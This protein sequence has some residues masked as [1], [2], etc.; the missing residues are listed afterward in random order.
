MMTTTHARPAHVALS[1]AKLLLPIAF[2]ALGAAPARAQTPLPPW[3][4]GVSE[5]RKQ[6]ADA[7]FEEAKEL[8][9]RMM[10]ADARAKYDEALALWEQPQLRLYLG[11]LLR[12]I[13][14]PLLAYDSLRRSLQWGPGSLDPDDEQEARATLRALVERDLAAVVIRC[15]EP[16]AAVLLDGV[17]WF[18][19]PGTER[20]MVTPGEHVLVARKRGYFTVVEHIAVFAGKEAS[21]QLALSADTVITKQRWPAWIP[22]VTVGA[23]AAL[24]AAGGGL[25]RHADAVHGDAEADF[26]SECRSSCPASYDD[27][28][29]VLENRL[30]IG[31]LIVGGAT[32]VTGTA[33]LFMN[34][35]ETYRPEDRGGV[36]LEVRPAASPDAAGLSARLVF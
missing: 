35:P 17:P 25:M 3:H 13:G 33:L 7:L 12:T 8:H 11:R 19:G 28:G 15:D 31:A 34:R 32:A 9:Q 23:G 21:G 30:A 14:R 16:G 24:V 36:K 26:R 29:S 18:V 2:L 27:A 22:W 4:Q 5:E 6:R 1:T 10:L 20:R